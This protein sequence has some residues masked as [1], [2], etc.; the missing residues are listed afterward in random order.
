MRADLEGSPGRKPTLILVTQRAAIHMTMMLKDPKSSV[1]KALL[2]LKL[3]ERNREAVLG[4][5]A[6]LK[7]LRDQDASQAMKEHEA[8]RLEILAKTARLRA[9]R[10]TRVSDVPA[11]STS[12]QRKKT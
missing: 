1:P 12:R 11:P 5:V 9:D 4:R 6:E 8:N 10:L 3:P 7:R 2:A